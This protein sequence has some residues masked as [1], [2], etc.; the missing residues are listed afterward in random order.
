MPR[1]FVVQ[2]PTK[3]DQK[4]GR[5]VPKLDLT[6]ALEYGE[7]HYLLRPS[8]SPFRIASVLQRLERKLSSYDPEQDHLL[9]L[10]N[11]VLMCSALLVAFAVGGRARVLQWD[12]R[13]EKYASIEISSPEDGLLSSVF[14]GRSLGQDRQQG[15]GDMVQR[16][17]PVSFTYEWEK[18]EDEQS[19]LLQVSAKI[20]DYHPAVHYL[21]NGDSGYPAEGSEVEE[22]EALLPDGTAL[23]LEKHPE[24]S[25]VLEELASEQQ[26]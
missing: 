20:S 21:R 7:L 5:L 15:A 22:L 4:L 11:P 26:P 12:R 13:S 2:D 16:G 9:L 1:V 19:I 24:L 8:Q 18:P 3:R 25:R 23:D 17:G 10:G 6:P 14:A